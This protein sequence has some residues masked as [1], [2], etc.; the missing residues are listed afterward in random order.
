MKKSASLLINTLAGALLLPVGVAGTSMLVGPGCGGS[1]GSTGNTGGTT[2]SDA[3]G[4]GNTIPPG[5]IP[6]PST[7]TGFVQDLT[8]GSNVVGPWYAYGDG[9]GP[10]AN[11]STDDAAN[12]DCQKK[13][14]FA[15]ADCTQIL[16]PTPGQPFPPADVATSKQCTSGVAALVMN[17]AGAADYT[18][19]WGG[20]ISLDFNNPGG[21][22]G[23]KGDLDLSA[24]QGIEFDFSG[25]AMAMAPDPVSNG[26]GAPPSSMRVNFPFTGEHGT[27]S[28]YWLGASKAASMLAPPTD[29]TKSQHVK[30]LWTDVGGPF[31]L[32]QQSPPVPA[33]AF[34]VKHVQSIQF[35]VFTSASQ[36]EPYSFCVANLALIP[37]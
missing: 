6:L 35:Q 8:G 28:P 15:P 24:Y 3:G 19:L 21:D 12:S 23:V 9:V 14:M 30:I 5:D 10:N 4:T 11:T 22:G 27:D 34:D 26:A 37:K 20:G 36:T 31:Y 25:F 18:D 16:S 32:S 29:P 2:G 13:G 7:A 33:P 1:S 17:K